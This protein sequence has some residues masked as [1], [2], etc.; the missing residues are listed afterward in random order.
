M[1]VGF[2]GGDPR[3]QKLPR[4][5]KTVDLECQKADKD[6]FMKGHHCGSLGLGF[7]EGP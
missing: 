4:K 1:Q 7:S 5:Q 6:A 3:K 2:L